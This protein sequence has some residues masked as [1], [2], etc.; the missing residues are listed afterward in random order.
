MIVTGSV[1]DNKATEM[2]I[3]QA[4]VRGRYDFSDTTVIDFGV[5]LTEVNNTSQFANVQRNTWGGTTQ[6]GDIA[7]L[8]TPASA[9]GAFDQISNGNDPRLQTDFFT[10]DIDALAARTEALGATQS[11]DG[12]C[13]TGLCPSSTFTTDRRTQEESTAF[14]VQLNLDRQLGDI[15]VNIKAGLRYEET[16]VTSMALVPTYS[17]VV[18]TGGNEFDAILATDANGAVIQSFT[19]L[20]GKYDYVLPNLDV[21]FDFT[22]NL[23]GRISYSET[24]GRPSYLD[25]Q[26][27]VTINSLIRVSGGEANGGN[28]GLLPIE[29]DNIDVSLEYYFGDTDYASVGY[30]RKDTSNFIGRGILQDQVLYPDLI[31][32]ATG[33]AVTFDVTAPVNEKDATIDGFEV[34]LQ[35]AIGDTGF[36]FIANATFMDSDASYDPLSLDEQFALVG[37]GDSAN[38]IV[39]YEN[40]KLQARVTYNWRD[41]FFNGEAGASSGTPGPVN[42][43]SAEQIDFSVSYDVNDNLTLFVEGIN[44]NEEIVRTYGRS[45]TE[46][47]TAAQTGARYNIGAR[48]TF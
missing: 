18:Q 41:D 47:K 19:N 8:L 39:Y 38:F 37:E 28:P 36:G 33:Q 17:Q 44:V 31:H 11:T 13:G 15:P 20:T 12:D 30:F 2:E 23:V 43:N 7:D 27:G 48:Y 42:F 34:A 5:Q 16:D 3:D 4:A 22:E 35:K 24:I 40:E 21:K 25:I 32:P 14:Y 29:S 26:G 45:V 46:V 1:F 6:P 9:A 10:F